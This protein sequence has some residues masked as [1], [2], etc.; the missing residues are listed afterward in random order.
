[1]SAVNSVENEVPA[2]DDLKLIEWAVS[3]GESFWKKLS[4]WGKLTKCL[5]RWQNGIAYSIGSSIA[6]KSTISVKQARQAKVIFEIAEKYGFEEIKSNSKEDNGDTS[7]INTIR[8]HLSSLPRVRINLQDTS[9]SIPDKSGLNWGQR[10]GRDPNQAYIPVRT[11]ECSDD[12]FPERGIE[13]AIYTDD[14]KV[15]R[16]VRAQDHGKA[17][18]SLNNSELGLYFR[19]RLSLTSGQKISDVHINNYGRTFLDVYKVNETTY[20]LDFSI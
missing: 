14:G 7:M 8:N 1:M 9:G 20:Y 2:D 19:S 12:F 4:R 17:I 15:I 3:F 16:C 5:E 6:K 11:S 18:H 13:F 10:D